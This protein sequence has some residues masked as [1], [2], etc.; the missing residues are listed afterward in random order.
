MRHVRRNALA[1]AAGIAVSLTAFAPQLATPSSA[2]PTAEGKEWRELYDTTGLSWSQVAT[3]CPTDGVTPCNGSVGG[4]NLT[5]WTWG[6]ASQVRA[7]LD[8][9]APELAT[10]EPPV[11]S[12]FPGFFPAISFL[13]TMHWTTFTSLTYFYSEWAG[14]WTASLDPTGVP[15]GAGGGYSH[16]LT[17]STATGSIGLGSVADTADPIRGVFLWRTP[18]LDYTAPVVAPTVTG[19]LGNNGW[20]RSDITINW[21][22]VD[23]ESAIISTQGCNPST[24]SADT[25]GVTT[26]CSAVSAGFG[27]PGTGSVTVKRD[28][29][30]P[31]VTCGPTPSFGLTDAPAY[32]TA[33]IGDS[34][35]GTT[36]TSVTQSVNTNTPGI[37]AATFVGTDL[38][39]NVT[40]QSCPY[41]V[42]I[43]TCKG[44]TATIIGTSGND[45]ITGTPGPDVIIGLA[46]N[47][48]IDG[49]GGNDTIC[50][51][52]GADLIQGGNGAD[53]IDGGAGD[54][55]LYGGNGAD[56]IDGGANND[57]IRGDAGADRCTSGEIRMSSCAVIY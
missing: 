28:T 2:A 7:L 1:I 11:V 35:S 20:Y 55:N 46:G 27:G 25:L 22:V 16:H 21:S 48:T 36:T 47:D 30:A 6:T 9:Y 37:G 44:K 19:T 3:V 50:G 41:T 56:D 12:G 29:V 5:G 31:T 54:D 18:G 10:V 24:V 33:T 43:P 17:G 14:G 51:G 4:R 39:G 26:T 45:T 53:V 34:L 57:S 40:N 52:D 32:V 8:D 42:T 38:A 13:S 15:I 23:P 49:K